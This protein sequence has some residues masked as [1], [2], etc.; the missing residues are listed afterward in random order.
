MENPS[1]N[2]TDILLKMV[3]NT[4]KGTTFNWGEG[5][6][7]FVAKVYKTQ[8]IALIEAT[9][10]LIGT[11]LL[12]FEEKLPLFMSKKKIQSNLIFVSC[13]KYVLAPGKN[14]STLKIKWSVPN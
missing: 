11:F 5:R 9:N 7:V 4:H 12:Q 3:L 6:N 14:M 10:K 13:R 8:I 1:T 2:T